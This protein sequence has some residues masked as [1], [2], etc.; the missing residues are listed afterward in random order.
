VCVYGVSFQSKF[1]T[2]PASQPAMEG[3]N[4]RTVETLH[5]D[6]EIFHFAR[7][8]QKCSSRERWCDVTP[9]SVDLIVTNSFFNKDKHRAYDLLSRYFL[10]VFGSAD[11]FEHNADLNIVILKW[12]FLLDQLAS[13]SLPIAFPVANHLLY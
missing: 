4:W 11:V 8:M 10:V 12:L 2:R 1:S 6:W 9:P 7:Q 13:E 3:R 5:L